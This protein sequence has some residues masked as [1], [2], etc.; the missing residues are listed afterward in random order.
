MVLF[1]GKK[2]GDVWRLFFGKLV[3][4]EIWKLEMLKIRIEILVIF[5]DFLK[6]DFKKWCNDLNFFFDVLVLFC[7]IERLYEIKVN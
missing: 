2:V 1:I 3:W 6:Y 4:V 5:F 7:L